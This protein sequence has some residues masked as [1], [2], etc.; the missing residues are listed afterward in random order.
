[1]WGVKTSTDGQEEEE[2]GGFEPGAEEKEGAESRYLHS[3]RHAGAA[4]GRQ[5]VRLSRRDPPKPGLE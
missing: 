2:E 5:H 1:M 3:D 4:H